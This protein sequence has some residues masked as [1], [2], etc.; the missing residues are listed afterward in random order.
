MYSKSFSL[1]IHF[2]AFCELRVSEKG[3]CTEIIESSLQSFSDTLPLCLYGQRC[4]LPRQQF[5]MMG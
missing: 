5:E 2:E 4:V 1:F 3:I